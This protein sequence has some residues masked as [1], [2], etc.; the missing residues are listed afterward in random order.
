MVVCF[1]LLACFLCSDL[2]GVCPTCVR[3]L[4]VV[5]MERDVG[6]YGSVHVYVDTP[7]VIL[8]E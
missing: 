3:L 7:L 4:L 1:K 6:L 8:M 2:A 5:R